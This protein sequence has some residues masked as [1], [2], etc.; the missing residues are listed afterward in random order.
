MKGRLSYQQSIYCA[1]GTDVD[2][3]Y[4]L[5]KPFSPKGLYHLYKLY[6]SIFV[7]GVSSVSFLFL[8]LFLIEIHVS[9]Q[10]KL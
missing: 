3:R 9:K 1:S 7:S 5:L 10:C 4:I 2:N 8:N 6:K